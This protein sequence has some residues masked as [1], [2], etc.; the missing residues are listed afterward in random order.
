[1]NYLDQHADIGV[2]GSAIQ[3]IDKRGKIIGTRRFPERHSVLRWCLC[4]FDP[5]AHPSVLMR[6]DVFDKVGGYNEQLSTAQDHDLWRRV[7]GVTQVANLPDVLLRLRRHEGNVTKVKSTEH[8]RNSIVAIQLMLSEYL[9]EKIP[10]D[11]VQCL[12]GWGCKSR[13]H[14]EKVIA[15]VDRLY[16]RGLSE[17]SFTKEEQVYIKKTT[18]QTLM[19]LAYRTRRNGIDGSTFLFALRLDPWVPFRL[20]QKRIRYLGRS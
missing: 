2:L 19:R 16:Q 14:R 5:I 12:L 4:L 17:P 9:D 10:E 7:S 11:L 1:M 18:S 20:L 15:L 3:I 8:R 13:E 6:R